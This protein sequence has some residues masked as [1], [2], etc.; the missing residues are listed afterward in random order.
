MAQFIVTQLRDQGYQVELVLGIYPQDDFDYAAAQAL[1]QDALAG[2]QTAEANVRQA[3]AA[4]EQAAAQLVA[5]QR[6]HQA[7]GVAVKEKQAF[8]AQAQSAAAQ[9]KS[10]LA[11]Y[12]TVTIPILYKDIG[13]ILD[14]PAKSPEQ[15]IQDLVAF[16]RSE[17]DA[18]VAVKVGR[19]KVQEA[20]KG[21]VIDKKA[22]KK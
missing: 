8:V 6:E 1:Y 7:R 10:N 19:I 3:Q 22:A 11:P 17:I 15:K 5:A 4:L 14:D 18:L 12:E 16:K 9:A 13:N 20:A 2:V 21:V